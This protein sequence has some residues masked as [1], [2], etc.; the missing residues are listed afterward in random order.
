MGQGV[1]IFNT[2]LVR[3]VFLG[4]HTQ[5]DSALRL[6][7]VVSLSGA[8][9]AVFIGAGAQLEKVI[10]QWGSKVLESAQIKTSVLGEQSSMAHAAMIESS[11]IGP[12]NHLGKGEVTSCLLGPFVGLHH[13]SLLIGVVWPEGRGNV[14]YGANIGS[15]HTGKA[16]DQEF[17]PGEGCFFGIGTTIKFPAHLQKSPYSIFSSG[18][19]VL[20]QRVEMPF[21]LFNSRSELMESGSPAL[22]EIFP[23]W[24]LGENLYALLRNELKFKQRNKARRFQ[25]DSRW[26]REDSALMML[27]AWKTC[28]RLSGRTW[29]DARHCPELGKNVLSEASRQ[30]AVELYGRFITFY[31]LGQVLGLGPGSAQGSEA[32]VD[33]Q[34]WEAWLVE[35][36]LPAQDLILLKQ[37]YGAEL[38][39]QCLDI[40]AS[41]TKDFDRG[42]KIMADYDAVHP[43]LESD[44][45]VQWAKKRARDFAQGL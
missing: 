29:Y 15:N 38:Q 12:N 35:Q 2:P 1:R 22:N 37:L 28:T 43:S 40:V 10:L 34:K 4:G 24:V 17:F 36:G 3:D 33:L 20:A 44:S 27:A 19:T 11:Y 21:S 9:E 18:L 7:Q 45:V 30:K 42:R 23:G 8:D 25:L 26:L 16:P 14:G 39:R 31:A 32:T 6:E 5:V 13:Q 41:K